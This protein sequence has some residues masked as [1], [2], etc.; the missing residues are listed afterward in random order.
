MREQ[1]VA[2]LKSQM[3]NSYPVNLPFLP[4]AFSISFSNDFKEFSLFPLLVFYKVFGFQS[5]F[6]HLKQFGLMELK[7]I[8]KLRIITTSHFINL[9]LRV[10]FLI[11][12]H[13]FF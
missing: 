5:L 13:T 10:R 4:Q 9:G 2:C 1:N 8:G 12:S 7:N 11:K 3:S 6:F